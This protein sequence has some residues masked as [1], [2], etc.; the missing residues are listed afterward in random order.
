[1]FSRRRQRYHSSVRFTDTHWL[2][3]PGSHR[4]VAICSEDPASS[5]ARST[6]LSESPERVAFSGDGTV[7]A[8]AVLESD[9]F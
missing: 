1:A 2:C 3:N 5:T 6:A 4:G 7:A 9:K 8:F